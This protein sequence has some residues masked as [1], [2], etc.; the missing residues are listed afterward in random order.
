MSDKITWKDIYKDFK[1]AYPKFNKQVVQYR[2]HDFLTIKIWFKDGRIGIYKYFN[3]D[4]EFLDE[5][6]IHKD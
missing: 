2:P 5:I 4:L 3:K 1:N 6:W